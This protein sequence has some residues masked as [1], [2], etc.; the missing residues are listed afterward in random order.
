M[1]LRPSDRPELVVDPLVPADPADPQHLRWFAAQDVPYHGRLVTVIWDA[2]GT[3][4]GRG[5]G[6][7][8]WVDGVAI[9]RRPDLGRLAA[10]LAPGPAAP[11]ARR[12]DRAERWFVESAQRVIS[13]LPI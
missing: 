4:Y 7:G 8:L 3:R 5:A 11:V 1:G 6:L 10:P 13:G 9:T 2:D 12:I